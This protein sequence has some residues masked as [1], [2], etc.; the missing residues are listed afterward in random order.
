M[1]KIVASNNGLETSVVIKSS[2]VVERGLPQRSL[3]LKLGTYQFTQLIALIVITL[4]LWNRIV[5]VPTLLRFKLCM[6]HYQSFN[7]VLV[8]FHGMLCPVSE[9]ELHWSMLTHLGSDAI[10]LCPTRR[11]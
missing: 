3:P 1:S 11:S 4:N 7:L 2:I 6:V 10:V 5:D 9:E 8:P